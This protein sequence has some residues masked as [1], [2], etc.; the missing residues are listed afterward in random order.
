[1]ARG[2]RRVTNAWLSPSDEGGNTGVV[3][4]ARRGSWHCLSRKMRSLLETP[5][6][7]ARDFSPAVVA[8]TN[9]RP[10]RTRQ[11][12][13]TRARLTMCRSYYLPA[14]YLPVLGAALCSPGRRSFERRRTRRTRVRLLFAWDFTSTTPTLAPV[15][16]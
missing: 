6:L 2:V 16:N 9:K 8:T 4:S 15:T 1:M 13:G 14:C 10:R 3:R 11:W 12:G 5:K 7:V